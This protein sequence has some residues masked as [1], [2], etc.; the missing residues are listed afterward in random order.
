MKTLK[1]L[2]RTLTSVLARSPHERQEQF[3]PRSVEDYA[4]SDDANSDDSSRD[5]TSSDDASSD[6]ASSVRKND[7]GTS[8]KQSMLLRMS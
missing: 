2:Y 3:E 6:D 4:S 5:D 1:T 8:Q 7:D